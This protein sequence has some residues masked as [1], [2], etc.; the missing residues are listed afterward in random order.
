MVSTLRFSQYPITLPTL[1]AS[2]GD[3]SSVKE[4]LSQFCSS[5]F[6]VCCRPVPTCPHLFE[7]QRLLQA[8][9]IKMD[10]ASARAAYSV[11]DDPVRL[12]HLAWLGPTSRQFGSSDIRLI[13][14]VVLDTLWF[15]AN[16]T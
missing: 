3:K 14:S 1:T 9:N 11:F 13:S 7:L 15:S 6:L 5:L 16:P 8:T 4:D 10:V 2:S 12:N